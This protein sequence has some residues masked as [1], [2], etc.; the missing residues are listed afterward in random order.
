MPSIACVCYFIIYTAFMNGVFLKLHFPS[1]AGIQKQSELSPIDLVSSN[2]AYQCS[3]RASNNHGLKAP[4]NSPPQLTASSHSSGPAHLVFTHSKVISPKDICCPHGLN[5]CPLW[6]WARQTPR[7]HFSLS[8]KGTPWKV[9]PEHWAWETNLR[10]LLCCLHSC[11]QQRSLSL[12]VFTG[13][14]PFLPHERQ[15]TPWLSCPPVTSQP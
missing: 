7:R 11:H 4:L 9:F 1:S 3:K 13:S 6:I 12:L 8:S 10:V 2:L 15:G 14:L 5:A